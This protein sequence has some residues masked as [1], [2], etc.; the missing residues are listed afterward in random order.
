MGDAGKRHHGGAHKNGDAGDLRRGGEERRH[1]RRRAFID[2][3]RPHMER[4]RRHLEAE[5]GEQEHQSENQAN[6]CPTF[7]RRGDAG[8]IH[9][10]GKA[11]NQRRAITQ[12]AGRHCTQ[13]EILQAGFGRARIVAVRRRDHVKRQAHQFQTEIKRDQVRGRDQQH[14]AQSRQ[15]HQ[16]AEFEFLQLLAGQVIKRQDQRAG[17]AG[18]HQQFEE[19]REIIDDETATE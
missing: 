3:G 8:E 14:H 2:V 18:Q 15:Q 16:H 11:V 13:H 5:A 9:R 19:A 17:R 7:R 1:R 12:H 6:A 10:A 4:H